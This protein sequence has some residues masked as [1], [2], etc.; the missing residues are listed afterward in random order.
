MNKEKRQS[1]MMEIQNKKD[2]KN[3]NRKGGGGRS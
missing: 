3:I 2:E 1:P